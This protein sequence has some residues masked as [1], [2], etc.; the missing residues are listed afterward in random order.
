MKT[1][2]IKTQEKTAVE[3]TRKER[4][5]RWA[6][7]IRRE[8]RQFLIAHRLEFWNDEALRQSM[9]RHFFGNSAPQYTN[10]FSLAASDPVFAAAG[11]KDDSVKASMDFFQLSQDDIH[12]FSCDCGGS[13]WPH[14]MADRIEKIA[15]R[16]TAIEQRTAGLF[17]RLAGMF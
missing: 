1:I 2:D 13:I 10:A 16:P 12:E 17:S 9:S 14:Q 4:L 6:D 15:N 3:L 8:K 7:M 5:L 11:L